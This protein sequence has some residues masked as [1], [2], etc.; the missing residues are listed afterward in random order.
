MRDRERMQPGTYSGKL[1]ILSGCPP[2]PDVKQKQAEA[3]PP[4][5]SVKPE[6]KATQK[7]KSNA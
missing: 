5:E 7:E 6:A 4:R 1:K 3:S 2:Q